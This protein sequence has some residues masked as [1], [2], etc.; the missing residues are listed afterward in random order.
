MKLNQTLLIV[1][2]VVVVVIFMNKLQK[3]KVIKKVVVQQQHPTYP[4][5]QYDI[6]E[7]LPPSRRT[8]M[9]YPYYATRYGMFI[10]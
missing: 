4:F 7:A 10:R 8:Y 1:L 9:R 6:R 3:P 2:I 5:V